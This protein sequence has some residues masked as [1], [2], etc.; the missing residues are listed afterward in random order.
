MSTKKFF[1][2]ALTVTTLV[3]SLGIAA[4]PASAQ[5][6]ASLNAQIAA[7]LAQINQLQSQLGTSGSTSM[8]FNFTRDLTLGSKGADVSALQQVLISKGFLTAVSA[9]TGFFGPATKA[10]LAKWQASVGISPAVGFFGPKSRAAF[11][12][13]SVNTTTTTT[14]TTTT[15]T[16]TTT[17][18]STGLAVSLSSNNPQTGA[19]ISSTSG[20]GSAARVPVL[21]VTFTAGTSGGATISELKFHKVGVLSD[22]SISGAYLVQNG[23]VVAQY[24]SLNQGVIDFS[25]LQLSV[26]AGQSLNLQL[27][28]DPASGLSAGNTVGFSLN[29]AADITSF[30]ANNNA[31]TESGAFPLTGNTFT[32]TTVSNPQL[33][34]LTI[35]STAI[36]NTVTAGTQN[37]IV[38]GWNFTV[39]NNLTWLKAIN[40]HVIGS[41]NKGDL[42]NVKLVVNG[43]Q[44]G[45]TLAAVPASGLAYF[46][47]SAN[48]GALNTG[49][50]NVQVFADVAGSPSYNFQFE[51]L[52]SYDVLAVDSQY[53]VPIAITNTGGVGTQVT[54]LKGTIT[55]SQ[56]SSTPTGNVAVG[57]SGVTLAKF[58]IYAGGEAVKVKW[59]DFAL[60]FTGVPTGGTN[61][62]INLQV[63]NIALTDDAGGQVGTTINTPVSGNSC[64]DTASNVNITNP[65]TAGAGF[66]NSATATYEDCFGTPSSNI[67]YIVP[68]NTTRVL[69]LRADVQ[70]GASFSTVTG[71]LLGETNNLQGLTSSQTGSSSGAVGSALSLTSTLLLVSQ[72]NGLASPVNVTPNSSGVK[73]GSYSFQASSAS[74]VQVSSLSLLMGNT[75]GSTASFQNLRVVVNG[76]QFGGTQGIVSPATTYSFSGSPF[77]VPAGQSVNVG[78]F[79]DILSGAVSSTLA[80]T[81]SSCTATGVTSFNTVNCATVG[82]QNVQIA[83]AAAV[84]VS[85]DGSQPS[86]GQIVMGSTG[87]TL[88][89]FRFTE[90][91]NAESVKITQLPVYDLVAPTSSKA[92]FRNLTLWNGSQLLGS[93]SAASASTTLV[94][95]G[96]TVYLYNFQIQG[97]P[98]I[99]PQANSV[100]IVL[101]GDAVP[102][103]IGATDNGTNVFSV[104]TTTGLTALGQSSNAAATPTLS[105]ASGNTQTLLRTVVTPSVNNSSA[106][107]TYFTPSNHQS[108][109]STDDLA[110]IKFGANVSGGAALTK[111]VVTFSGSLASSTGFLGGVQLLD[112]NGTDITQET[113]NPATAT[114]S[115][116]CNGTNTCTVTWTIPTSTTQANISAGGTGLFKLRINDQLG[117]AAQQNT[118]L[119]LS[120]IIKNAGDINYVDSLDSSGVSI[121]SVPTNLVPLTVSSFALPLGN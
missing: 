106:D 4:L 105:S 34:T 92:G 65:T 66:F 109:N 73:I 14:T 47:A 20:G 33:A 11:A 64:A 120:A 72:D 101:K 25:G 7:L 121:T 97:S 86:A 15:N 117:Q 9:P 54:I 94:S 37:N 119:S 38:G 50:N 96:P 41:A 13:M 104:A 90:T 3:W 36:A 112:S 46:D 26:A 75:L 16:N 40:F 82:G 85:A 118:A 10:A 69:S 62:L 108:R 61:G 70:Q 19:L 17:A 44:I 8:S 84:T 67:N 56:D 91:S 100:S 35:N 76:A 102:Y 22:S 99:V 1:S 116:A 45:A 68:A 110:E 80:T 83:G 24:N 32:V 107:G 98:I 113:T 79:A 18:P 115:A 95:G 114:S 23:Q 77:T 43:K 49:S 21:G 81:L 78:V 60:A 28:I 51:I 2:A 31:I 55:V 53:G 39:G 87:N 29:S 74:G 93:V 58:D 59:L 103:S 63:R 30:D 52:N 12:A 57:Q 5:S 89:I 71:S 42:R 48:P 27:A 111:L 88:A 6:T